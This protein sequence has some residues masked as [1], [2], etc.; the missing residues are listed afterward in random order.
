MATEHSRSCTSRPL[1]CKSERVRLVRNGRPLLPIVIR[2]GELKRVHRPA[3]RQQAHHVA[4]ETWQRRQCEIRELARRRGGT[5]SEARARQGRARRARQFPQR[6]ALAR[7]PQPREQP[8]A[9]DHERWPRHV[10][11]VGALNIG[12]SVD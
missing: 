6:R 3:L 4:R 12:G 1:P 5:G 8:V 9:I 11:K 2:V 10:D 7:V